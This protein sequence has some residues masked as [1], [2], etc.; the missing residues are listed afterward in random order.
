MRPKSCLLQKDVAHTVLMSQR[1]NFFAR[2]FGRSGSK[3]KRSPAPSP[4]SETRDDHSDASEPETP[5]HS[6]MTQ[7]EPGPEITADG[8]AGKQSQT[9]ALSAPEPVTAVKG[10]A[11][12]TT[13]VH[14]NPASIEMR[15]AKY[16]IG[17]I[18]RHRLFDFYGIIFDVD[19][20]FSNTD[21]WYEA[22]PKEM[23]PDKDQPYYHLFAE[24]D[25]SH[26]VA[27]VSEQNLKIDEQT[28]RISHPDIRQIFDLTDDGYV[29]KSEQRN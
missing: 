25:R 27:Y 23:R 13:P 11:K 22:I 9:V 7:A 21:E 29:L 19:P 14:A 24:N 28:L 6:T 18:V 2:I 3:S 17:Q 4:V 12:S 16:Q 26:Y 8:V 1:R 20:V 10:E 5:P 15:H